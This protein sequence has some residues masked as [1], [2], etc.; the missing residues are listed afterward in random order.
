MKTKFSLAI[1][2]GLS[3]AMSGCMQ[4]PKGEKT[5]SKEATEITFPKDAVEL[6]A[7]LESSKIEWLGTKPTGTHFGTLSILEGSIF[8][9]D[10]K[11]LGGEFTMDMNSIDVL[12]IEA[13]EMKVKLAGHLKSADFFYVDSFPTSNFKFSSAL[14]Y[15]SSEE[16]T[17]GVV[18]THR[19]EGNLTLRGVSRKISFPANIEITGSTVKGIT[20]QFV[21]NRT[22]WNVNYGSKS[23]F[24]NLKDNFIHDE[25][26]I[27]IK[28]YTK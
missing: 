2:L 25:I 7:D 6:Q 4:S 21:I 22:E 27:T 24:D 19:I 3:I 5:K 9:K 28:L 26:G 8:I 12:D 15:E 1:V 17:E 11:L 10:G 16:I 23:I 14:P 13:P 18:P 20:P